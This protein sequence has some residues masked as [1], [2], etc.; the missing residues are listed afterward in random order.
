MNGSSKKSVTEHPSTENATEET[1]SD[2]FV[3]AGTAGNLQVIVRNHEWLQRGSVLNSKGS[4][5]EEGNAIPWTP[6][7]WIL[8]SNCA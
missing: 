5:C 1:E 7:K 8:R 3:N 2:S 6:Q 4:I